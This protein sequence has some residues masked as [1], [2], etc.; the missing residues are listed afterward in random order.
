MSTDDNEPDELPRRQPDVPRGGWQDRTIPLPPSS[1]RQD[2]PRK[3]TVYP[4][5]WRR[6]LFRL[7][8]KRWVRWIAESV[9]LLLLAVATAVAASAVSTYILLKH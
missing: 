4:R 3:G 2:V 1:G 6:L 8:R 7:G 5:G 9:W